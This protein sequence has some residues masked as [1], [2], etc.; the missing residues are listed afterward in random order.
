MFLITWRP[1]AFDRMQELVSAHPELRTQFI[2]SL[3]GLTTELRR[4][5][6]T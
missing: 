6:D 4:A 2:Y 1:F 3:R 5:A